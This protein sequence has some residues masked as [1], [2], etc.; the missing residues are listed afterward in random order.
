MLYFRNQFF[1]FLMFCGF[2]DCSSLDHR[3]AYPFRNAV[4]GKQ[5]LGIY[6]IPNAIGILF[7]ATWMT[8]SSALDGDPVLFKYSRMNRL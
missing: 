1:P 7:V 3:K 8:N 6:D 5:V 4:Y 2:Y